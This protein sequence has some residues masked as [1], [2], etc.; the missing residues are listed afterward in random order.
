ML[1]LRE[2]I[3]Q[4]TEAALKFSYHFSALYTSMGIKERYGALDGMMLMIDVSFNSMYITRSLRCVLSP[5]T[6]DRGF[7]SWHDA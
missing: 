1:S 4:I 3:R 5:D 6:R 2:K 7:F